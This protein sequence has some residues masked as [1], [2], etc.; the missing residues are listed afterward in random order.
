MQPELCAP[1]C[2]SGPKEKERKGWISFALKCSDYCPDSASHLLLLLIPLFILENSF[3]SYYLL[4]TIK[5]K[6]YF[7]LMLTTD[8]QILTQNH[9]NLK[10][11]SFPMYPSMLPGKDLQSVSLNVSHVLL[12][13][14][15][16]HYYLQ[17]TQPVGHKKMHR[18]QHHP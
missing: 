8:I 6:F 10:E 14:V 7:L 17:C 11:P 12:N 13:K 3:Y 9:Y 18:I 15:I 1:E 4:F 16:E 2:Y 5:H